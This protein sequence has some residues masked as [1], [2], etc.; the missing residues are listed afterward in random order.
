MNYPAI[1]IP[2]SVNEYVEIANC[3]STEKS[4]GFVNGIL[5]SVTKHLTEQGIINKQFS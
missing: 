2:V 1:P 4:G 3:Y 5:Y